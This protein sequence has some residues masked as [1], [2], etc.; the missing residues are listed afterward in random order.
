MKDRKHRPAKTSESTHSEIL[1]DPV[2]RAYVIGFLEGFSAGENGEEEPEI[3][4]IAKRLDQAQTDLI[5]AL[6]SGKSDTQ[7]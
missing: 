4:E 1:D 3:D 2:G 7:Q 5:L 6:R